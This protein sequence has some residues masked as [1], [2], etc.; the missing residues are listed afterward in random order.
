MASITDILGNPTVSGIAG[1]I[2][3]TLDRRDANAR[4]AEQQSQMQAGKD[5]QAEVRR[6]TAEYVQALQVGDEAAIT[7]TKSALL[8]KLDPQAQISLNT[9][10][11]KFKEGQ[12]PAGPSMGDVAA[13]ARSGLAWDGQKWTRDPSLAAPPD[14]QDAAYRQ[15]QTD[16]NNALVD[17][18][19]RD[20]SIT[21][22][23][24]EPRISDITAREKMHKDDYKSLYYDEE[25]KT[26][27][28]DAPPMLDYVNERLQEDTE[29]FGWKNW[30]PE[31]K[32]EPRPKSAPS[33]TAGPAFQGGKL[34]PA[35]QSEADIGMRQG[36][37]LAT[38]PMAAPQVPSLAAPQDTVRRPM[39]PDPQTQPYAEAARV[40]MAEDGLTAEQA[41]EKIR[42]AY[43]M[44]DTEAL[45]RAL[46]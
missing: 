35:P 8:P 41:V 16:A 6:L 14:P 33:I 38:P 29:R 37:S 11:Q 25:T 23:P 36:P 21:G 3:R 1:G 18:R 30:R 40:L 44:V 7:R 9:F 22:E 27:Q 2:S 13:G 15:S 10:E 32:P 31:P 34:A 5:E 4:I 19:K 28:S 45:M 26:W 43:P 17:Q 12:Q 20:R 42:M 39:N 24:M 46:R